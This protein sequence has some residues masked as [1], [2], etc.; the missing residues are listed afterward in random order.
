MD[1]QSSDVRT[2][3]SRQWVMV[4]REPQAW[5]SDE[6]AL[7]RAGGRIKKGKKLSHSAIT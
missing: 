4:G 5:R 3:G 1:E 2:A 6:F 7:S